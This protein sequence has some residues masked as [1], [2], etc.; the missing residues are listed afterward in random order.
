MVDIAGWLRLLDE[1]KNE[2]E[3]YDQAARRQERFT[4]PFLGT[5]VNTGPAR[6]PVGPISMVN[7]LQQFAVNAKEAGDI[8]NSI[9]NPI[10]HHAI[11]PALGA[12]TW[13]G[14]HL[15]TPQIN[16]RVGLDGVSIEAVPPSVPGG[17]RKVGSEEAEVPLAGPMPGDFG[18]YFRANVLGGGPLAQAGGAFLSD[19]STYVGGSLVK[20]G[21]QGVRSLAAGRNLPLIARGAGKVVDADEMY[22]RVM[23]ELVTGTLAGAGKLA[24]KVPVLNKFT[25]P[26]VAG[27][28]RRFGYRLQNALKDKRVSSQLENLATG[29]DLGLSGTALDWNEVGRFWGDIDRGIASVGHPLKQAALLK[30]RRTALERENLLEAEFEQSRMAILESFNAGRITDKEYR[31]EITSAWQTQARAVRSLQMELEAGIKAAGGVAHDEWAT[32][33]DEDVLTDTLT[34]VGQRTSDLARHAK[35]MGRAI[36]GVRSGEDIVESLFDLS[37][38]DLRV[39]SH[40]AQDPFYRRARVQMMQGLDEAYRPVFERYRDVMD[41]RD[42]DSLQ[43]TIAASMQ[44]VQERNRPLT[45]GVGEALQGVGREN[46]QAILDVW[47]TDNKVSLPGAVRSALAARKKIAATTSDSLNSWYR[48]HGVLD[49][50]QRAAR[51]ATALSSSQRLL[52]EPALLDPK[53][54]GV[55]LAVEETLRRFPGGDVLNPDELGPVAAYQVERAFGRAS[56]LKDLPPWWG[57]FRTTTSALAELAVM[58]GRFLEQN[59]ATILA[60]SEAHNVPATRVEQVDD[61]FDAS[62]SDAYAAVRGNGD[63]FALPPGVTGR[64]GVMLDMPGV[65][66]RETALGKIP[67]GV[68]AIPGALMAHG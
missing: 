11:Q 2:M 30:A 61:V 58:S 24:S 37:D 4:L 8:Y 32:L 27:E 68:R 48:E 47:E 57:G 36:M 25:V 44:A 26:A 23:G 18:D 39:V 3:A 34:T 64:A 38:P 9:A 31:R 10:A 56:G 16:W 52:R 15:S 41:P 1:K 28:V 6:L 49:A 35:D 45:R 29:G 42:I 22:Q 14:S 43:E 17:R 21:A 54:K 60:L 12:A 62:V 13:A 67:F 50:E 40:Q 66:R 20:A 19:P 65:E 46:R 55:R 5:E 33:G 7:P 53:N 59:F 63:E 51:V